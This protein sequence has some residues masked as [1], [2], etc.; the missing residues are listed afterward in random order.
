M[1]VVVGP[2]LL[3]DPKAF[4]AGTAAFFYGSG[5]DSYPIRGIGLQ[6]LLLRAGVIPNRWDA[7]PSAQIQIPLLAI[8]LLA[9]ALD[10]RRGWRWPRFWFWLGLEALT[11]FAFGR[12]LAPNYLD[13]VFA[14]FFVAL[15]SA[16]VDEAPVGAVGRAVDGPTGDGG[17][18][19]GAAEHE[20][21]HLPAV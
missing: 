5:V 10:L 2:F 15:A 7:F 20:P 12:V 19:V 18:V 14:F 17:I 1:A 13:L 3:W 11:V 4:L 8:V 6:G 21:G 16:L 9:A